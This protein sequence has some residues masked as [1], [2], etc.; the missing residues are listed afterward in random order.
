MHRAVFV[1]LAVV[2]LIV[3]TPAL[4]ADDG[5]TQ[6][7][8]SEKNWS[9]AFTLLKDKTEALRA[10]KEQDVTRHIEEELSKGE[11]STSI[12]RIVR[13][14][15]ERRRKDIAETSLGC[16]QVS[17]ME[18]TAF[19]QWRRC[20]VGRS[21]SRGP[22][23]AGRPEGVRQERN[24]VLTLL[25]DLMVDEAF[26]QYKTSKPL[27]AG[28]GSGS[29]SHGGYASGPAGSGYGER[30][31]PGEPGRFAGYGYPYPGYSR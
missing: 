10:A 9:E 25:S 27:H 17:E 12:A 20:C 8:S 16:R 5:E 2:C 15:L 3:Q 30:R 19:E 1:T 31:Y 23:G 11:R 22:R 26:A 29:S 21:G 18:R 4:Y 28:A 24:T 7:R 13:S 14:V 6:C